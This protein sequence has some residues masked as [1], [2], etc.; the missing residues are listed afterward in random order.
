[1]EEAVA[2][3]GGWFVLLLLGLGHSV[4]V[5]DEVISMLLILMLI[6]SIFG[7]GVYALHV[8]VKWGRW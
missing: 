3:R 2:R 4:A 5:G 6:F 7:V 1:M 8:S